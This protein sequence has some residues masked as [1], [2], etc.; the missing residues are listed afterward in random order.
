MSYA[1]LWRTERNGVH[2]VLV[3][4]GF[5]LITISLLLFIFIRFILATR[6]SRA[7]KPDHDQQKQPL[8]QHQQQPHPI[9]H[10]FIPDDNTQQNQHQP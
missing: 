1:L 9:L 2:L 6:A 8:L 10:P 7:T 5:A 3:P 4:I